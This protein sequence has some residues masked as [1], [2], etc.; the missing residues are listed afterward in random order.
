MYNDN[1]GHRYAT[2]DTMANQ[3]ESSLLS[4]PPEL[5]N[6]IYGMAFE[7]C[8]FE[9]ELVNCARSAESAGLL[10]ASKQTFAEAAY[11]YYRDVTIKSRSI[12]AITQYARHPPPRHLHLIQEIKFIFMID[13]APPKQFLSSIAEARLDELG[14]ALCRLGIALRSRLTVE[15]RTCESLKAVSAVMGDFE[16]IF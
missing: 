4:L 7:G 6:I 11:F 10:L 16:T 14:A 5:R 3:G 15:I 2:K 13:R 8:V 9:V 12:L 1:T